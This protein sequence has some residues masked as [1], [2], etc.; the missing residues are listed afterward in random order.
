M[1]LSVLSKTVFKKSCQQHEPNK[2]HIL[3]LKKLKENKY[4]G[5]DEKKNKGK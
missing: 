3:F 2:L 5:K 1:R 4:R